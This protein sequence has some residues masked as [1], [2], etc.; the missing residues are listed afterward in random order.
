MKPVLKHIILPFFS[1]LFLMNKGQ[2]AYYDPRGSLWGLAGTENQGRLDVLLPIASNPNNLFYTDVQGG[3]AQDDASYGG[4]GAGLRTLINNSAIYGGYVFVDRDES[5]LH[6]EFTVLSPGAEALF[7]NWDF[8]ANG[9]FP[10]NE[11]KKITEFFPSQQSGCGDCGVNCSSSQ[12]AIFTGH[13]ELGDRFAALEEAGP[14]ADGE[15]GYTFHHLRNTQLHAGVYYFNYSGAHSSNL[16]DAAPTKNITGIEGRLEVP[17][18]AHWA[19]TVESSYDN[20]QHAEVV[21]GLRLNLFGVTPAK[22]YV[23]LHD[24]MNAPI[25]R[26]V[27]SLATGSGIPTIRSYKNEGLAVERSNIYFFTS[28][29][30]SVFVNSTESGTFENPLRNDQF[31]QSVVNQIGNNANLYFN[32]GTYQIMGA[33][34]PPNAIDLPL[35]DSIYGRTLDFKFSA[36][37]AAR[38]E[39]LGRINLLQGNNTLDSIQLINSQASTGNTDI[40]LIALNVQSA[41]NV[42]LCNDAIIANAAVTGNL[43]FFVENFASGIYANNSQIAIKNSTVN[44]VASVSGNDAG[45]NAAAGIGGNS[46]AATADSV[47]NQFIITNS[48]ISGLATVGGNVSIANYASG[49]GGNTALGNASFANNNFVIVASNIS[50]TAQ[51]G[52]TNNSE[53]FATGIGGNYGNFNIFGDASF[54]GNSFNIAN[55][56]VASSATIAGNNLSFN[57]S[58]GI[59]GNIDSFMNNTINITSS[60]ISSNAEVTGLNQNS[61]NTAT[62]IGSNFGD[63]ISNTINVNGSQILARSIVG[64]GQDFASNNAAGIGSNGFSVSPATHADFVNNIINIANSTI[65]AETMVGGNNTNFSENFA[66]GVGNNFTAPGFDVF[67]GNTI[68]IANSTI[69]AT[70]TVAGDNLALTKNEATGV[71]MNNTGVSNIVKIDQST[72]NVLTQVSGNNAGMNIATGL[73]AL[74][75]GDSITINDSTVNVTAL[76]GLLNTG[77]NTAQGIDPVGA[78]T[79]TAIN[80]TFNI[81]QNP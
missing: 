19:V 75:A 4:I 2:A 79:V 24:Q 67:N 72:I 8:R 11:R 5:D 36:T 18:N 54:N 29:G 74:S 51:V 69:N 34:I 30:G 27:G 70:A 25:T 44:A 7:P 6:N 50:G 63:F 37:G 52:G 48:S 38:P 77:T 12:G 46:I 17:V 56:N 33:G 57:S 60:T 71:K 26:N 68:N 78:G 40:D 59:G 3:Y 16:N 45:V 73:S 21:G 42:S 61:G 55:S 20:Y 15:V 49:I 39:L 14:G 10:V 41:P 35:S 65:T 31:S 76:V 23:D 32:T 64:G 22:P 62:G 80:T 28:Q 66:T 1:V 13:E 53:N 9:Y 47:G 58:A 43:G 81:V